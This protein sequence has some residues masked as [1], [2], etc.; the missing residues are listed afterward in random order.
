[1]AYQV[2]LEQYEGPFELLLNLIE[3]EKL[4]ITEISLSKVTEQFIK[5]LSS[6]E[7]L[8]PEELADFLVVATKLLLIKSRA[9]LP[10]LQV[11]DDEPEGNLEE[12]LKIYR[13]FHDAAI[14]M[15][16]KIKERNFTYGRVDSRYLAPEIIFTPPAD[17]DQGDLRNYYQDVLD[18]L[19]PIIKLPSAAI[20]KSVT[21]KEKISHLQQT[22]ASKLEMSF[23]DLINQAENKTEVIVT[24]LALLELVKQEF[25]CVK[26]ENNFEDIKIQKI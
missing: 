26:Q 9:L 15:E 22:L 6:V 7:E 13:E 1:M 19:E 10:Y 23:K 24:F 14:K 20:A 3:Q 18:S 4:K 21:L 17:F 12:Q 25:I 16:S 8:Y 5:H 2:K 11:D